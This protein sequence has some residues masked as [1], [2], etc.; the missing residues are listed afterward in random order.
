MSLYNRGFVGSEEEAEGDVDCSEG[1]SDINEGV[2]DEFDGLGDS[3]GKNRFNLR[4]TVFE[5][6]DFSSFSFGALDSVI[7][8]TVIR[9]VRVD[10]K[11][12]EQL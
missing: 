9:V 1:V 7:G 6:L 3:C 8:E 5:T 2:I 4:W 10:G 12:V 11:E